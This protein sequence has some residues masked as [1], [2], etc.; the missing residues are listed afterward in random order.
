[1]GGVNPEGHEP[2]TSS[3]LHVLL[4]LSRGPVHGYGVLRR[5]EEDSGLR[6]GPGTIYGT[7]GRL[8]DAG[9][10]E[11]AGEDREDPRRGRRFAITPAGRDILQAEAERIRRLGVLTSALLQGE[12]R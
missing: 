8:Q 6:M 7:L 4:A 1:M 11:D 2:L 10:V 3:V 12:E 5:V 9:L